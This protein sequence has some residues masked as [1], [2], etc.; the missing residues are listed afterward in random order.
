MDD[1]GQHER[2]RKDRR[3]K[4]RPRPRKKGDAKG[5]R[6][7]DNTS[8]ARVRQRTSH[9]GTD[10]GRANPGRRQPTKAMARTRPSQGRKPSTPRRGDPKRSTPRE[11]LTGRRKILKWTGIIAAFSFVALLV[12][13]GIAYAAILRDLPDITGEARGTDQTSVVYD[14]NGQV[15]AKL[16]AEQNRTKRSLDEI[17]VDLR[18]A[19]IATE[20][21]RYYEH[22]GVDPW[23]VARALWVDITQGKRHGGSTITQQYVVNA[24]VERE[25]TLTRKVKEGVL[26]YRLEKQYSKDE[27]LE[28]YLNTIYFGHGAYGVEAASQ[29]Y[30]GKPVTDLTLAECAMIA[31]VIRSPGTYSPYLDPEEARDR[32]DT[33]LGQML[34][35][36][37]ISSEEHKT[38][39]TEEMALAGLADNSARAPYFIE[40]IKHQLTEEYGA[41]MVYRS[42]ISAQT[43]LDL[44]MQT[45]AE[46]A[47]QET[48]NQEGD[49]SAAL[50]ALDPQTGEILAMVGGTDFATQQFNVAVQGRRQ[51]GSA[52]KPFVLAT[53]LAEGV[54]PEQTFN[55]APASLSLPN[56]QTWKVSGHSSG[57]MM[58]LRTA[59]EKS[60]NAVFAQLILQVGAE[61]VVATA[62]KLGLHEGILPVPAIALGG[63][64]EGVS[65]L[66]MASAYGTFAAG[67]IHAQP[68]GLAEVKNGAG[69]I[70]F[71]AETSAAPAIDPAVAYLTTD[72][73]KGVIS[74][75]TGTAANIGRY[76][77]GKT[78]TTQEYRDAWFVGYTPQLVCAVWV[79]YPDAQTEMKNVHGRSVTGGSFPAEIWQKFMSAAHEGI[80]KKDFTRP[81]GLVTVSACTETGLRAT[82]WCPSTYRPLFL[83]GHTPELCNVHTGP[84]KIDIP[85]VI[86]MTKEKAL[87]LLEQLMLLFEVREQEVKG[88]PAGVVA[89]QDP[90]VGSQGTTETVVKI[91]VSNGGSGD[92]PPTASFV[93][94][95]ESPFVDQPV[96]FDASSSTDDGKIKTYYWEFGDGFDAGGKTVTHPFG[97]PGSVEVTLWVTDDKGQTS[98]VTKKIVVQ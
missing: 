22:K 71:S 37:F 90:T 96:V 9:A 23:G 3:D 97:D 14:R 84:E 19:V 70:L 20:D 10:P 27:I 29:V 38:A 52:F 39:E 13:G 78:G 77:A 34:E 88:V 32:R 50:V 93:F 79:G 44:N 65:P 58:R 85:N 57:G 16:F 74:R 59:T 64:E 55:S 67:G 42:G 91:V 12:V 60:V 8:S 51:P 81:E 35:L 49:P 76:A 28:L 83:T 86:G 18:Q 89:S 69:E 98:S 11:P 92:R 72:I 45:A 41:D 2:N 40:Y 48:L 15:L 80:A 1:F 53:A 21:K 87:A 62:E 31:G 7:T 25:N 26:A 73:L 30:F 82:E 63:L 94:G 33:V 5:A 66:E 17:P 54:L 46:Q 47:V 56:G 24:F 68:F 36:D 6:R 4:P 75:G 95:P 43:T 61:D